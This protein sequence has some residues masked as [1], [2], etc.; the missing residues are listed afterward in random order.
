MGLFYKRKTK[1]YFKEAAAEKVDHII[2]TMLE[3]NMAEAEKTVR[4]QFYHIS[5]GEFAVAYQS[6]LIPVVARAENKIAELDHEVVEIQEEC[7]KLITRMEEISLKKARFEKLFD[8]IIKSPLA[9]NYVLHQHKD[10]NQLMLINGAYNVQNATFGTREYPAVICF[11]LFSNDVSEKYL[12]DDMRDDG[13]YPSN[14]PEIMKDYVMTG[15]NLALSSTEDIEE[16]KKIIG[17][18]LNDAK[19][20]LENLY[21]I[22]RSQ[23]DGYGTRSIWEKAASLVAHARQD[24]DLSVHIQP[25]THEIY[26]EKDHSAVIL[27][28]CDEG[29]TSAYYLSAFHK[30]IKVYDVKECGVEGNGFLQIADRTYKDILSSKAFGDLL[31]VEN[32]S[33]EDVEKTVKV[34]N[35]KMIGNRTF[36]RDELGVTEPINPLFWYNSKEDEENKERFRKVFDRYCKLEDYFE[37][38]EIAVQLDYNPF[39]HAINIEHDGDVVI[40][41]LKP[42]VTNDIDIATK[43]LNEP[44]P[45]N[46]FVVRNKEIRNEEIFNSQKFKLLYDG[47]Q[48][49]FANPMERE[50][51]MER[52]RLPLQN[53]KNE[54]EETKKK[55]PSIVF[56]FDR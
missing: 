42:D 31:K 53:N 35:M 9:N 30:V 48:H 46:H 1:E 10:S 38:Q 24:G 52:E 3:Y 13:I 49:V 47:I 4:S 21:E 54:S 2:D 28:Y 55:R 44:L 51:R 16:S 27:H 17:N 37:K 19:E 12:F 5:E 56:D 20:G 26:Y 7:K 11:D 33:F 22:R 6:E 18:A 50:T 25:R 41:L 29:I 39:N 8:K 15:Q 40:V 45:F 34:D 14:M 32:L 36:R 23:L 43:T